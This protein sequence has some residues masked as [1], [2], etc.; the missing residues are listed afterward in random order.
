MGIDAAIVA[1]DATAA[2]KP[3]QVGVVILDRR[4]PKD[5]NFGRMHHTHGRP[6]PGRN[7]EA[8]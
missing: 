2:V 5:A 3:H 4:R 7:G 1:G 8:G 6:P